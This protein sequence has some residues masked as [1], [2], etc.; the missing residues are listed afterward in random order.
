MNCQQFETLTAMRCEPMETRDQSNVIAVYSPF[1]FADGGAIEIFAATRGEQIHL[2][3]EGTTM[4]HVRSVG[5]PVADKRRWQPLK[6][7]AQP[8]GVTLTDDGAFELLAPL[9]RASVAFARFTS[10]LIAVAAWEREHVGLP[11]PS[12]HLV[13]EVAMHLR[14]WR[15][16]LELRAR[17][18]PLQ[19]LSGKRHQF[20]FMLGNEYV[21]AISTNGNSTGAE[22]RKIIDVRGAPA[23]ADVDVRVVVDDRRDPRA[24]ED[25]MRILGTVA[26]AWSMRRLIAA[27][28][29]SSTP[30]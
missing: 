17:P 27:T 7:A 10:A 24:A 4:L 5:L 12:E 13:D 25:E 28:A 21:D 19:G 20:N 16:N 6:Q 2:F 14:A 23:T 26:R 8:Y 1:T 9:A 18:E 15:P 11:S 29:A 22:L 30:H 3:D